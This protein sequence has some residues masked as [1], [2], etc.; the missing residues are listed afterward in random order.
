MLN[1]RLHSTKPV[2]DGILQNYNYNITIINQSAHL[3][4]A[5]L[6]QDVQRLYGDGLVAVVQLRDQQLDAPVAEELHV[7]AQQH[8]QVLRGVQATV[9][10]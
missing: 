7:G 10:Q 8:A 5:G 4:L 1:L 9:L 3:V 6:V 2:F